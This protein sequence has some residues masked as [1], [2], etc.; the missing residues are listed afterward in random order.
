M[1]RYSAFFGPGVYAECLKVS[2]LPLASFALRSPNA[3]LTSSTPLIQV[4]PEKRIV[5]IRLTTTTNG[6]PPAQL[7]AEA[8]AAAPAVAS[9][10]DGDDAAF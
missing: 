5:A 8:A 1:R 9:S 4:D 7:A 3:L 10:A 6:P 2:P